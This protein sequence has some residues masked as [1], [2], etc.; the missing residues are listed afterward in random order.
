MTQFYV[1]LGSRRTVDDL[2]VS[3]DFADACSEFVDAGLDS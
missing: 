1:F 2:K 3:S